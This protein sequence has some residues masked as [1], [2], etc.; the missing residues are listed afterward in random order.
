MVFYIIPH[1]RGGTKKEPGHGPDSSLKQT[2]TQFLVSMV[3]RQSP[4]SIRLP[5]W[6]RIWLMMPEMGACFKQGLNRDLFHVYSIR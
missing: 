3:S 2:G 5:A 4:F 6:T 1:C